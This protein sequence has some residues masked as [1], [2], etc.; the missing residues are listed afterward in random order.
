MSAEPF[1]IPAEG[2]I[3]YQ[4]F[5]VDPGLK[6]D[7][8]VTAAN[9]IPGNR[10]VVHHAIVFIRPPDGQRLQG[11]GW[12]TAYVPGQR[13]GRMPT[14]LARRVPAGSRFVFQMHYTPNGTPQTDLTRVALEFGDESQVTDEVFSLMA[15]NQDFEIPP[16]APDHAV[17]ATLT[18]WPA[19]S[20]LLALAP[21][22]HVR[23]AACEV[24]ARRGEKRSLLL[25]VPRYD[26]DWQHVYALREPIELDSL[27]ALELTARFDNSAANPV[28]PDPSAF[29]YWGDQ[30]WEEMAVAFFEVAVPRSGDAPVRDRSTTSAPTGPPPVS[31]ADQFLE[32]FDANRDGVVVESEVP[33]SVERFGFRSFDADGDGWLTRSEIEQ[34]A[35]RERRR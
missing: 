8:W 4:Y 5:V 33:P 31:L 17:Q 26:F 35:R 34:A 19:G 29:V 21:H 24:M 11:V 30:T 32:R 1:A 9:V 10:S 23:G 2:T 14:G 27:D 3:D 15:I 22:M 16:G 13:P 6:E 12:L 7:R 18:K 25:N 28:N 20:R